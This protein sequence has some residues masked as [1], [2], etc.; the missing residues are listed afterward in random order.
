MLICEV[1]WEDFNRLGSDSNK[2]ILE[3]IYFRFL[4]S[5]GIS[6]LLRRINY[7]RTCYCSSLQFELPYILLLM[8]VYFTKNHVI[9]RKT[10]GNCVLLVPW[11]K[12]ENGVVSLRNLVFSKKHN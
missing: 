10:D 9:F 7:L 2:F 8:F 3:L 4:S 11:C 5:K 6:Q 1:V 12:Y